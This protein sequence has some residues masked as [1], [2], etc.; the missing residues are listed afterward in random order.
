VCGGGPTPTALISAPSYSICAGLGTALTAMCSLISHM[1]SWHLHTLRD[2]VPDAQAA[3]HSSLR[4]RNSP[5]AVG[6]GV[7]EWSGDTHLCC[8]F[9]TGK[10]HS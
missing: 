6:R 8:R 10:H 4:S 2:E 5:G 1:K 9:L 7:G 3:F